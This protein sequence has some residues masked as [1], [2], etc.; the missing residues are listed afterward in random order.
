MNLTRLRG[1]APRG[2]RLVDETPFSHWK[3]TTLVAAL[4][5]SGLTAPMVVDGPLDGPTFL[6]YVRQQLAPTPFAG[7]IVVMDNLNS[8]KVAS[9]CAAIEAAGAELLFLQPYSRDLTRSNRASRSLNG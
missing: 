4:R 9:V 5:A 1:R 3:S 7:D 2:V 6:T 8:C